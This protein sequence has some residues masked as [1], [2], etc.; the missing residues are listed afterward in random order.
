[1]TNVV[2]TEPGS[3]LLESEIARRS[4][5]GRLPST[6][7]KSDPRGGSRYTQIGSG[8][9]AAVAGQAEHE[10][11]RARPD[12]VAKRQANPLRGK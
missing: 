10:H 5:P 8:S 9:P 7:A 3:G 11:R 12:I 4:A 1:M 6:L 2:K